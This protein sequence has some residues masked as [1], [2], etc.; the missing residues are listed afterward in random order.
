LDLLLMSSKKS[1]ENARKL[2][3]KISKKWSRN[4]W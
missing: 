2:L 1:K 4:D 3:V